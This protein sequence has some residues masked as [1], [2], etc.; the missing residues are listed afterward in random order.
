MVGTPAAQMATRGRGVPVHKV[1]DYS[2][3]QYIIQTPG[4]FGTSSVIKLVSCI[5]ESV[6]LM[7]R[8][9]GWFEWLKRVAGNL[10]WVRANTPIK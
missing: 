8:A 6:K 1:N 10:Q 9:A 5:P 3:E 4:F 7:G 2:L